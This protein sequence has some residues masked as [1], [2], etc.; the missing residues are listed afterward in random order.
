MILW[1]LLNATT[2]FR[3]FLHGPGITPALA[4]VR[5]IEI[6][7]SDLRPELPMPAERAQFFGTSAEN[8]SLIV[9]LIQECWKRV[10]EDRPDFDSICQS[11]TRIY[12]L[13]DPPQAKVE[14]KSSTDSSPAQ[15]VSAACKSP[16]RQGRPATSPSAKPFA[17]PRLPTSDE[18]ALVGHTRGH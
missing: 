10:P 3:D 9:S 14:R 18:V 7:E 5:C 16:T 15:A 2:P 8:I 17:S 1:E 13:V 12:K 6:G 11:L 4:R